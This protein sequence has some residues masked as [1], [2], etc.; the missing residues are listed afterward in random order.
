MAAATPLWALNF[1]M[2]YV[3]EGCYTSSVSVQS[4]LERQS[5]P[6]TSVFMHSSRKLLLNDL[7]ESLSVG[8]PVCQESAVTRLSGKCLTYKL[9]AIIDLDALRY[10][11]QLLV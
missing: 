4:F 6:I 10:H 5:A 8:L 9:A 3:V 1:A 7:I 11:A 2:T